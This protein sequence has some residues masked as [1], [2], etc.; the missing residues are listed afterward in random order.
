M[1][2]IY[3]LLFLFFYFLVSAANSTNT[4]LSFFLSFFFFLTSFCSENSEGEDGYITVISL[5]T[6][7]LYESRIVR[8]RYRDIGDIDV[9]IIDNILD[10]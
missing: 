7:V 3:C 2:A 8:Y 6:L 4:M 10:L 9:K 5:Y 1:L